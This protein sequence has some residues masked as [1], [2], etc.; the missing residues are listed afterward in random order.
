MNEPPRSHFPEIELLRRRRNARRL[1]WLLGLAVVLIYLAG[2]F[3]K[4]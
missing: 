4:R 2:L 3:I 1:A